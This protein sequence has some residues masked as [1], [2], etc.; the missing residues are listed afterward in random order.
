MSVMKSACQVLA[1]A[2]WARVCLNN[3]S[4]NAPDEE[5]R[6]VIRELK[7]ATREVK[8][9]EQEEAAAGNPDWIYGL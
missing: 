8:K 3:L 4:A 6:H 2:A 7:R 9:M 1:E 5:R